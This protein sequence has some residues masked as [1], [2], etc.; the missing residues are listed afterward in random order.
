M[1]YEWHMHTNLNEQ[2]SR[3]GFPGVRLV[4]FISFVCAVEPD[5]TGAGPATEDER[6]GGTLQRARS[7]KPDDQCLKSMA[8]VSQM[9]A[10]ADPPVYT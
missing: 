3:V 1:E 8:S 5:E 9:T 2:G 4:H 7:G 10:K 6:E